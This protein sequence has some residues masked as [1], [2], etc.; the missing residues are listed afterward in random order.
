MSEKPITVCP[1]CGK[2]SKRLIGKGLTPIFKG[3]GFY[4]TDY[5]NQ[6]PA[7]QENKPIST[8]GQNPMN[9]KAT[10]KRIE[11]NISG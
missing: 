4:Q 7:Q 8:D 6:K 2:K 3:S 11:D 9:D 10:K 5:K 1:H